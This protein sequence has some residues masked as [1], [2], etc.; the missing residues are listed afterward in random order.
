[1]PRGRFV[2]ITF[3]FDGPPKMAEL[4]PIFNKGL[5]WMRLNNRSWIVWTTSTPEQWYN[6]F[7]V[8][9]SR[10]DDVYIVEINEPEHS[11]QLRTWQWE[12][13]EKHS[14][15]KTPRR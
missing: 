5:D 14:R 8:K 9:L 11:G 7:K 10:N 2:Q 3:R 1:M 6:R 13:F 12:W 4:E 15:P